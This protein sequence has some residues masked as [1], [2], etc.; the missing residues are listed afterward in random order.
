MRLS[1]SRFAIEVLVGVMVPVALMAALRVPPND[2]FVTDTAGILSASQEADLEQVLAEEED[3]SGVEIA[4]LIV[5]S[6]SGAD[7]AQFT[8]DVGRK[9]GVGS[10]EDD[11]GILLIVAV[12]DRSVFL[13]TGYGLE[14]SVPDVVAKQIIDEVIAPR[15]KREEYAAGLQDAVA[16]LQ[17]RIAGEEGGET[18]PAQADRGTFLNPWMILLFLIALDAL[19]AFLGRTKS[20]WLGGILG[21]VFGV[22]LWMIAGWLWA[23]PAVAIVGFLFDYVVSRVTYGK[24]R[25]RRGGVWIGGGRF[26]GG[27]GGF[28]GFGGG[29]FGG[30]GAHG[31]W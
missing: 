22:V 25:R 29:S 20:F 15:F 31:R 19:A 12:A 5:S 3:R 2:G 10:A 21:G 16:T 17:R 11:N 26:G 1:F 6:L 4:I 14:G 27:S 24:G 8:V 18:A 23:I 7:I 13:A 28:G 9:W 30:G